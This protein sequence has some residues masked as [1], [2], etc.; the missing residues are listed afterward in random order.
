MMWSEQLQLTGPT[1]PR[2][3]C[4]LCAGRGVVSLNPVRIARSC[5]TCSG[6]GLQVVDDRWANGVDFR[7][8]ECGLAPRTAPFSPSKEPSDG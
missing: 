8:A 7:A 3:Q 5:P 4:R 2:V 6:T 1:L